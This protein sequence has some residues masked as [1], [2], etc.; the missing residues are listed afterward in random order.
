MGREVRRVPE[1]WDHPRDKQ[2]RLIPLLDES[3]AAAAA[4]WKERFTA[5]ESRTGDDWERAALYYAEAGRAP[6]EFW[7]WDGDPPDRDRHRPDWPE[8]TR[9]H[10]QMYETTSEGTPISPVCAT[11]EEC[12]RW[13]AD[14]GASWFGDMTTTYEHWLR[15]TDSPGA[16]FPVFVAPAKETQDAA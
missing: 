6:G 4:D 15:I 11:K 8:E 13:C 3:F 1:G 7:E 5:W 12:A 16:S 9:T 10:W 14:H 2:G